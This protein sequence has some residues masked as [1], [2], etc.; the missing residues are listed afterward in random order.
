MQACTAVCTAISA[1]CRTNMTWCMGQVD[2]LPTHIQSCDQAMIGALLWKLVTA[3]DIKFYANIIR[4]LFWLYWYDVFLC[5][6]SGLNF[7]IYICFDISFILLLNLAEMQK[8]TKNK[9][10][11]PHN[12]LYFVVIHCVFYIFFELKFIKDLYIASKNT[13]MWSNTGQ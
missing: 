8:Q 3:E 1:Q 12:N 2:S 13:N 9:K 4:F 10:K 11:D 7:F 6:I 5:K